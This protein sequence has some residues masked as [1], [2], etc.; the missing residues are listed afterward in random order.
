MN[1]LPQHGTIQLD[2]IECGMCDMFAET[3]KAVLPDALRL[4]ITSMMPT[5][6]EQHAIQV[7]RM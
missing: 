2:F 1:I 7:P 5:E 4:I 3:Q 6:A